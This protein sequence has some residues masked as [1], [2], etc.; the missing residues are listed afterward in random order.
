[1]E[2]LEPTHLAVLEPKSSA[3][4]NSATSAHIGLMII[5]PHMGGFL[6]WGVA[7]HC[8]TNVS[9][10]SLRELFSFF[11]VK[12]VYQPFVIV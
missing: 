5:A 8:S 11:C 1:M 10:Y 12:G 3:S 2:G 4:A 7:L 6:A 9:T